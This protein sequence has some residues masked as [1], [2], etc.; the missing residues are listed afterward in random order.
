MKKKKIIVIT[1]TILL[2]TILSIITYNLYL[3]KEVTESINTISNKNNNMISLMIETEM[4]SGKYKEASTS[5][6]PGEDYKLNEDLSKCENGSKI[7]Y[8]S[9]TSKLEVHTEKSDR[10]Y[11]YFDISLKNII[12]R[13][14]DNYYEK[15][16]WQYMDSITEVEFEDT[17]VKH[18]D[19]TEIFDISAEG[20]KSVMAY[21]VGT[22]VYIQADGKIKA[23]SDSTNLFAGFSKLSKIIG[24]DKVDTSHVV[25]M[26]SMFSGC[27]PLTS[28]DGI[29]TWDIS[30]V[31]NMKS[32]FS[33]CANLTKLEIE[34]WDVSKVT[35]MMRMFSGCFK[36]NSLSL[37]SWDT[38]KVTNMS[39]M[40]RDCIKLTAINID[41]WKTSNVTNM[42]YMFAGCIKLTTLDLNN[43]D[44][45]KVQ[46]LNAMFYSCQ[47]LTSISIDK[48]NTSK[49]TNMA[50]LFRDCNA[51]ATI[52]LGSWNT[53]KVTNMAG[54]FH[55]CINLTKLD[56]HSATFSILKT[57]NPSNYLNI[58]TNING[59]LKLIVSNET[60]KATIINVYSNINVE[61][62]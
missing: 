52:N 1:L 61:V 36:L 17:L 4:E 6:W 21:K 3:D 12:K 57:D 54:M 46:K 41:S 32:L 56:M 59:N 39:Y 58:F 34:S 44:T 48:W 49:V 2:V 18:N 30:K 9:K 13:L 53:S 25:I 40:F 11:V 10:C 50:Y 60:E 22:K 23:N 42:E 47:A 24:L 27:E 62:Y 7:T 33:D 29:N 8:D 38:S 16:I 37:N 14:T 20:D 26:D 15:D 19:A 28:L 5:T 35:N 45:S 43:W 55:N 31:T 51:I